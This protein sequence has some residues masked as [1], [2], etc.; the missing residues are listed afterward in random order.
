MRCSFPFFSY[1]GGGGQYWELVK[2]RSLF[3][4]KLNNI[5][6]LRYNPIKQ[7]LQKGAIP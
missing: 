7:R 2:D 6:I 3:I 5:T 4:K 1:Y